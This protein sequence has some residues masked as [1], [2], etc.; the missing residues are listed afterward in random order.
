MTLLFVGG[1]MNLIWIVG[2]A[3]LVLVEKLFPTAKMIVYASGFLLVS[4]GAALLIS[5]TF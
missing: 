2:L 5:S 3:V 4:S 1:A